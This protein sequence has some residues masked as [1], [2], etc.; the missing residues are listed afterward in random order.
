MGPSLS[1]GAEEGSAEEVLLVGVAPPSPYQ[2]YIYHMQADP[3]QV[4]PH[5][6]CPRC[7]WCHLKNKPKPPENLS[8]YLLPYV[9]MPL[10]SPL[11]P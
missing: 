7:P 2:Q 4:H 3:Q 8:L 10:R 1:L 9:A 6:P 11:V 5:V